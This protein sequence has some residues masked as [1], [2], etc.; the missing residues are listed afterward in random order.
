MIT[1]YK[2]NYLVKNYIAFKDFM[3][4]FQKLICKKIIKKIISL[5]FF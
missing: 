1:A 3:M 5:L 2:K 4:G